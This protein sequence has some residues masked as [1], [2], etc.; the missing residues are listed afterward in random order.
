MV[1]A[2]LLAKHL[3]IPVEGVKAGALRPDFYDDRGQRGHEAIDIMAAR[4]TPVLAAEDG[5]IVKLF[6]SVRGGMT[7]YEFDPTQ[8]Y[9][10]YY[11]HLDRYADGLAEGASVTRGQ[12]IG[13]VGSTG[14]ADPAAPHLHFAIALLEPQKQW[15]KGQALDPYPALIPH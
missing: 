5:K 15:W 11:A 3:T 14:D 9:S 7:I 2:D 4:G 12:V 8:T 6:T 10:Y 13:F 1:P